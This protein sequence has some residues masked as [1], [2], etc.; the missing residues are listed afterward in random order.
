VGTVFSSE[1]ILE[2][3]INLN[4]PSMRKHDDDEYVLVKTA[5]GKAASLSDSLACVNMQT[6]Y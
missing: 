2:S 1:L 3:R 5:D 6:D 4:R